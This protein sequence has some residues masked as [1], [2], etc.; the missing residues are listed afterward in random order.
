[1]FQTINELYGHKLAATDGD[2]GTVKDCYFDDK[3]WTV[4]YLVVDT[5]TWLDQRLVLLSPHSFGHLD[6]TGKLIQVNLT[7]KQIE[8]SP[9]IDTHRPVSRQYEED[10]YSYYGWPAYWEGG[11]IWGGASYPVVTPPFATNDETHQGGN[12]QRDDI[13]L[14]STKAVTGYR[15]E[16]TYDDIGTV[17]DFM[18]DPKSWSIRELMVETGHWYASKEIYISPAQIQRISYEESKVCVNL[19]KADIQHTAD[20]RVAH[21]GA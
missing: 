8:D 17:S 9:S 14:R 10:Y 7:K 21:S 11:G 2:I 15:I 5:G 19:T 12:H 18:M 1:M 20:H 3:T 6:Q 4:R 16:A 13:H